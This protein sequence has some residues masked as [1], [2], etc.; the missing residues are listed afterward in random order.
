MEIF[1]RKFFHNLDNK[2]QSGLFFLKNCAKKADSGRS[3]MVIEKNET[4]SQKSKH[5][6][7]IKLS[8]EVT[9]EKLRNE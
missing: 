4:V 8:E 3:L 5:V 9:F 7:Q 1:R 6:C 2:L